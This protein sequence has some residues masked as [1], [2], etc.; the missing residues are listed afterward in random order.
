MQLL[1]CNAELQQHYLNNWAGSKSFEQ[2]AFVFEVHVCVVGTTFADQSIT[3]FAVYFA[4]CRR[5]LWR[6]GRLKPLVAL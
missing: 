1:G 5:L 2:L 3:E 4:H 6:T